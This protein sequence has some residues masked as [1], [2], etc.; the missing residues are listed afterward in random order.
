MP[1]SRSG[2]RTDRAAE[3]SGNG[4]RIAAAWLLRSERR[5]RHGRACRDA[6]TRRRA[7]GG[8][9][10]IGD[11]RVQV[12]EPES[13]VVDGET[14][15]LTPVSV[16]NPHAVVRREPT[17]DELLRLGPL[18]ERHER[19]PERTN[20][21]LSGS[22]ARTTISAVVW[23][24]GAGETSA[25]GSSAVAVA[26]AAIANGWCESPIKVRMP[27]GELTSAVTADTRATLTGPAER[28][29]E[30]RRERAD[31]ARRRSRT[32]AGRRSATSSGRSTRS[33][34]RRSGR[35]AGR[36][37]PPE[38]PSAARRAAR[39]RVAARRRAARPAPS[40]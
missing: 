29:C 2:T 33:A 15:E 40:R 28:I 39:P 35:T 30:A 37:F 5:R 36:R 16:G 1:R 17:R 23:E 21:Q 27:G 34:R 26:A 24:R 25:S 14:I 32:R 6:T 4:T 18:L 19:F 20:V 11:G 22:T 31:R 12:S 8:E 38:T 10:A 9:I 3:F 13:I 7:S